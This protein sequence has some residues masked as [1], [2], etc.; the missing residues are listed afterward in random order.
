MTDYIKREDAVNA[1]ADMLCFESNTETS[2]T[3]T[4][5]DFIDIA[6]DWLSG[7]QSADVAP[8]RH[9]RW[10]EKRGVSGVLGM[11]VSIRCS[12]C[13]CEPVFDSSEHLYNYCPNCGAKMDEEETNE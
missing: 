8:V 9:G 10:I 5:A 2:G 13:G 4:R 1:V 11:L 6:E 12:V 7:A 3:C